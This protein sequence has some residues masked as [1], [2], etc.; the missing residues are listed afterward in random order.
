MTGTVAADFG[1]SWLASV[2][3]GAT[4]L[5]R[6]V[7][8]CTV[9]AVFGDGYFSARVQGEPRRLYFGVVQVCDE[10]GPLLCVGAK[11][12]WVREHT[13]PGEAVSAIRFKRAGVP[14]EAAFARDPKAGARDGKPGVHW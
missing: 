11:F 3:D 6:E 2:P 14:V 1:Q 12:W 7:H 4:V 9:T 10:D 13:G 8:S 5:R